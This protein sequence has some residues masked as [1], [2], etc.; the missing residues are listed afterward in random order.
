ME[1]VLGSA[2]DAEEVHPRAE[3]QHQ[4][5]ITQRVQPGEPDLALAEIHRRHGSLMD[6]GVRLA[7]EEITK[8]VPYVGRQFTSFPGVRLCVRAG[9]PGAPAWASSSRAT[10]GSTGAPGPALAPAPVAPSAATPWVAGSARSAR[11]RGR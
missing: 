10:A 5:A 4:V 9:D 3:R 2:E 1:R 6:P 7:I 11:P 8:R